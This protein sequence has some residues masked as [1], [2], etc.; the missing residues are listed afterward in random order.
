M[1]LPSVTEDPDEHERRLREQDEERLADQER[2]WEAQDR[3]G[4]GPW[5]VHAHRLARR[6]RSRRRRIEDDDQEGEAA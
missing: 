2:R 5:G 4:L 3:G 1:R 6:E